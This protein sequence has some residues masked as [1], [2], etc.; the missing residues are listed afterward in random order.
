MLPASAPFGTITDGTAVQLFTLRNAQGAQGAQATITNDGGTLISLQVPGRLGHVVLD[1]DEVSGY[2]SA[3]FRQTTPYLGALIG[4]FGNR[5]ARGHFELDGQRYQLPINN[6]S[7]PL[8]GGARGFDQRVW[9]APPGTS[10]DG[11]TLTLSGL[12]PDGEQGD[13]RTLRMTVSYALTAAN[14]LILT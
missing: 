5:I 4:C 11:P 1:F 3:A 14:E 2:Q 9:Q 13:P 12:S 10:P 6:G 7:N 8:H